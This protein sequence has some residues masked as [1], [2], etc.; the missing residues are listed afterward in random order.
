VINRLLA[1][2]NGSRKLIV[3]GFVTS[4]NGGFN[5]NGTINWNWHL[6]PQKLMVGDAFMEVCDSTP[7]DIENNLKL[8]LGKQF[9]PWGNRVTA[10]F[11]APVVINIASPAPLPIVV[12]GKR[13]DLFKDTKKPNFVN[14]Q[15]ISVFF[16]KCA[17]KGIELFGQ[18]ASVQPICDINNDGTINAPDWAILVKF[19]NQVI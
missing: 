16:T 7:S 13:A 5:N 17:E 15:D 3:S 11:D 4:G 6:D 1:D 2:L 14:D 18:P 9:C 10:V 12:D 8:W 19:R